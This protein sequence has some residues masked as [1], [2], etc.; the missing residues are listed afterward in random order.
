MQKSNNYT[1]FK[2]LIFEITLAIAISLS[3][4]SGFAQQNLG[5]EL[6]RNGSMSQW[7]WV[8]TN[9]HEDPIIFELEKRLNDCDGVETKINLN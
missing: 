1:H 3:T 2:I 5:I 9:N 7:E 6:L 4:F 8:A